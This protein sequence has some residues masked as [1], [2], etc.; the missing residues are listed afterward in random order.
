[1]KKSIFDEI[2]QQASSLSAF[3]E[4]ARRLTEASAIF[5]T[6]RRAAEIRVM[7]SAADVSRQLE[8]IQ[9][10]A[11]PLSQI[12]ERELCLKHFIEEKTLAIVDLEHLNASQ[13]LQQLEGATAKALLIENSALDHI[14]S[15]EEKFRLPHLNEAARM[16]GLVKDSLGSQL[17]DSL[18]PRQGEFAELVSSLR[19]PWVDSANSLQSFESVSRLACV[20]KALL[21]TAYD[22]AAGNTLKSLLGDWSHIT[23]SESVFSDWRVRQQLYLDSGFD[24]LL[25]VL[26]EPAFTDSLFETRILRHDL[27]QR[28]YPVVIEPGESEE[29]TSEEY[30]WKQR[31]LDV[32]EILFSLENRLRI[33]IH[34]TMTERFGPGWEKKR[35]SSEVYT[36]WIEK[37]EKARSADGEETRL[38]WYADFTDYVKIIER[39]DNWKEIFEPIFRNKVDVQVSFMRLHPIRVSAAHYRVVTKEDYLLLGVEAQRILRAIGIL[40]DE[41]EL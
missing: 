17:I 29:K 30:H 8:E 25:T 3:S 16:Y 26:P 33:F 28:E 15:L 7:S 11:Q 1:M 23:F 19:S 24:H 32:H 38:L 31:V 6:E 27:F 20:G 5:E 12:I 2:T 9:K 13:K 39:R 36:A 22:L 37:R 18:L 10:M 14:K 21:P 40:D 4:A 34:K 35:V 41:E